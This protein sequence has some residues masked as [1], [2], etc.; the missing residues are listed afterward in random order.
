MTSWGFQHDGLDLVGREHQGRHVEAGLE[1]VSEPGL[2]F[3]GDS[4]ADQVGHV[5]VDRALRNL[6]LG[7]ERGGRHRLP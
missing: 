1:Q 6:Q 3:Y 7:G 4:L 5:P 2:A